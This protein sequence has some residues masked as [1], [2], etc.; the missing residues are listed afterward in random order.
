VTFPPLAGAPVVDGEH[1]RFASPPPALS[2]HSADVLAEAG[3][4]DG[5]IAELSAAGLTRLGNGPAR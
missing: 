5:E 4:W 3:Y 2:E 1:L